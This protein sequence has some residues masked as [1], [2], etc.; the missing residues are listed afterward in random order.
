MMK[1]ISELLKGH[2]GLLAAFKRLPSEELF[3]L[4]E[5]IELA[6][7]AR[8]EEEEVARKRQA[9]IAEFKGLL[10]QNG[11]TPDEL[12]AFTRG[13]LRASKRNR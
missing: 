7:L 3:A 4:H 11:I 5:E 6:A 8:M 10:A 9:T 2:E 1:A 12:L 13:S